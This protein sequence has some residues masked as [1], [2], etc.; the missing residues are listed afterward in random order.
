MPQDLFGDVFVRP[1]S[2]RPRHASLVVLS[3]VAHGAVLIALLVAPLLAAD[4]LPIPQRAIDFMIGREATPVVPDPPRRLSERP[5]ANIRPAVAPGAP[6]VAPDRIAPP[7]G[8]EDLP[9]A[10]A[11]T[12]PVGIS[13]PVES[14]ITG[15]F[16]PPPP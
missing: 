4:A 10:T 1:R 14:M 2:A 5:P 11:P 12:G 15:K 7:T 3:V 8:L 9:T 6:V 13:G 16:E